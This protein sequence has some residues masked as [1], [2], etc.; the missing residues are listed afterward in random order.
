MDCQN[1]TAIPPL[2]P[3]CPLCGGQ[4]DELRGQLR[5]TRCAFTF[6]DG[7]CGSEAV[8]AVDELTR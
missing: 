6:C 5:C 2:T 4:V 1:T 8:I 3:L 7:C